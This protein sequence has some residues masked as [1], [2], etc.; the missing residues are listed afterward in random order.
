HGGA[1]AQRPV[2]PFICLVCIE[3]HRVDAECTQQAGGYRAIGAGAVDPERPAIDQL[4]F[5]AEFELV[6]F[7]VTAK[8]VMIVEVQDA[9]IGTRLGTIEIGGGEPADPGAN[10]NQVVMPPR[11]NRY[12]A[13]SQE[14][15]VSQR[16]GGFETPRVAAP[17]PSESG[18]VITRTVLR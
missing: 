16:V 18:R 1:Q 17:H 10:D 3:C 15:A 11:L 12:G 8:M 7:G 6:S 13:G 2:E 4:D 5:V 9:S 14:A